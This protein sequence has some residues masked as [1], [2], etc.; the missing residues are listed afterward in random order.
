MTRTIT[1]SD[2]VRHRYEQVLERASV[3]SRY[4]RM[5]AGEQVHVL[6]GGDGP[7]LVLL[8]GSGA[9]AWFFLPLL[10][11]LNGFRVIAPDRPS[12]G[13]SDPIDLPRSDYYG[14]SIGW[15]D[16]LFDALELD[17]AALLG[18]S[19]GGVLALRYTLARPSRIERLVLIGPPGLPGTRCPLPYRF[20]ATPGVG[21]LLSRLAPPSPK[22]MLRFAKFMGEEGTL[23]NHPD[24][25]DLFVAAARDELAV[26]GTT[27]EVRMLVSPFALLSRYGFRRQSQVRLDELR[28]LTV[29]T[30]LAWGDKEPLGDVTVARTVVDLIPRAQLQVL[31]GGHAP[32]L[33]HPTETATAVAEFVN[34][35]R[36]QA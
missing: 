16:R 17:S 34:Q 26:S 15:L 27:A 11:E 28:R 31:P 6:E 5:N 8:H 9:S 12:Q 13:L 2:E 24:L 21:E 7:P 22:S 29:P 14:R 30:L 23:A 20:M 25:V 32:W 18:H 1:H 36:T 3:Q 10:T 33:G 19:A 4:V 35:E